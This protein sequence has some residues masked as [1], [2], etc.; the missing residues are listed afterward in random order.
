VGDTVNVASRLESA[1]K[2]GEVLVGE[3]TWRLTRGMSRYEEIAP[4]SLK[5]KA[6][7]VPAY[8]LLSVEDQP[9]DTLAGPF[10]GRDAELAKLLEAFDDA[11]GSNAARLVT[12]IGSPGLG[13]TRLTRE[14]G[15]ALADRAV[16]HES[17]C[18]PAGSATFAPIA[19]TV[20][21]GA[22]IPD[23]AEER[24]I[25]DTLA[26]AIPENDPDRERSHLASPRS[27]G[28]ASPA[29]PRRRSGPSGA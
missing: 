10:V 17:R 1:A 29:Q 7:P 6:E 16:V 11:V 28:R 5:G 24:E 15:A 8:R 12:I 20:R 22:S 2:A 4:L 25:L 23:A 18:D 26:A 14:L 27:W 3:E 19:E 9:A 21:A 13:K